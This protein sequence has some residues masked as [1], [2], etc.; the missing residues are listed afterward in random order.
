M[1]DKNRDYYALKARDFINDTLFIDM[2]PLYE[3]FLALIPVEAT[4]LDA[5][6]GSGRD[7]KAFMKMGYEV[8]AFD[9]SPVMAAMASEYAGT[10]VAEMR[11]QEIE[12]DHRFDGIWACASLLHVPL[13][14]LPGVFRRLF[15]S[16]KPGGILYASFKYGQGEHER[17]GRRFTDM[18]ESGLSKLIGRNHLFTEVDTW[19][20]GDLRSEKAGEQW[21]NT[22]LR[23]R[24]EM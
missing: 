19:V 4:I 15:I 22:L 17:N 21:L 3:R 8:A 2:L 12:D 9:A 18:D 16:L 5:G 20:T 24:E 13:L 7:T 1:G 11:F 14:E 10:S 6:C 23:S